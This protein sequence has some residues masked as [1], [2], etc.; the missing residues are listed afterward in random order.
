MAMIKLGKKKK[1]DSPLLEL[2]SLHITQLWEVST[3]HGN[4]L[5]KI[6]PKQSSE[7]IMNGAFWNC[8]RQEALG[9]EDER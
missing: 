7:C 8:A 9:G 6:S 2:H 4:N 3:S 5:S 1:K